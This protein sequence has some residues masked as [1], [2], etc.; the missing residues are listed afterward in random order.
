MPLTSVNNGAFEAVFVQVTDKNLADLG[1]SGTADVT[2]KTAIGDVPISGIAFDVSS[3]LAG[4]LPCES[5]SIHACLNC[6]LGINSFD[7][8]AT[9]SNIS[10]SGSGGNGGNQYIISPLTS[11]LNNPSNVSLDTVD[12]ALPVYY[13]NV[14]VGRAAF[15]VRE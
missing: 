5:V 1:L 3:S 12:I 8:K 10:I 7:G 15:N 9:I 11:T 6:V 13:Q 4:E 2:A 14:M